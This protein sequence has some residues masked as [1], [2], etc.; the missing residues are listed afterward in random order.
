MDSGMTNLRVATLLNNL[1]MLPVRTG[2]VSKKDKAT[3]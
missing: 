3:S 1:A 2:Y